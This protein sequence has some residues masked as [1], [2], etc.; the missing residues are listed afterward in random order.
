MGISYV[1]AYKIV[2]DRLKSTAPTQTVRAPLTHTAYLL[3]LF[4]NFELKQ[5]SI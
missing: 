1:I 5:Y 3:E 4:A 2:G